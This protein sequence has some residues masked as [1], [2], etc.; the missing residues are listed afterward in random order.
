MFLFH[1]EQVAKV[2]NNLSPLARTPG[3]DSE[4]DK[5]QALLDR[6]TVEYKAKK[7]ATENSISP[8]NAGQKQNKKEQA[9]KIW[10]KHTWFEQN[11]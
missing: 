2:D 9:F 3:L 11:V 1:R 5:L 4:L 10:H 6:I 7:A 8:N